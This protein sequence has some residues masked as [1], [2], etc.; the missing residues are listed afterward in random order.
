MRFEI[1]TCISNPAI[2]V[3]RCTKLKRPS[4]PLTQAVLKVRAIRGLCEN[5][6]GLCVNLIVNTEIAEVTKKWAK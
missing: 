3:E 4:R 5:L 2:R 1:P 6:S